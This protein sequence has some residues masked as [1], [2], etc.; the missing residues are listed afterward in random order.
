MKILT[1]FRTHILAHKKIAIIIAILCVLGGWRLYTTSNASSTKTQYV[2]EQAQKGTL[3]VTVSA[4]GTVSSANTGS[5][6]TGVSGV[7]KKI[8]VKNGQVVQSGEKI[9]EMDLDQE[10][11]QKYASAVASYNSAKN[12]VESA[13]TNLYSLQSKMFAANEKFM[14]GAAELGL[15]TGDTVYIQ[16]NSDWLAS[17]ATYKNQQ[18]V[19][20]Q[21]QASLNSAYLSLQQSSPIIYA[22]IS[23]TINGLSLQVGS[24]LTAQSTSLGAST[25]QKIASIKTQAE[26]TI[27][28]NLTE[29]DIPKVKI[30]NNATL[31]FDALPGKTYTGSIVSIDAVGAVSSGVTTYPAVIKLDTVTSDIFANM[32]A[33]A[34]II[35]ETKDGVLL[36]PTSA[37]QT[38]NGQSTV[39]IMKNNQP[40]QVLVELGTSS[41]AQIEV[42]SGVNEGDIVITS[43]TQPSTATQRTGTQ[44]QSPF[45]MFGGG[46]GRGGAGAAVR[47]G[48]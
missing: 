5:V 34:S 18:Q 22:P 24:I 42:V 10:S 6:A 43:S 26:P 38:Q 27:T 28:V 21:T 11:K 2:T 4:S 33:Q 3:I 35:T 39:R 36:V 16:Q 8:F 1:A 19:I 29:I 7:V 25:A 45:S 37:V 30:G 23:G 44:T 15:G 12:S 48:R 20:A 46:A 40:Q 17:E 9:A 31:M 13:K 47:I 41:S 32:S 14:N